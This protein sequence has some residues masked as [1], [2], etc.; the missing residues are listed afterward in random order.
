MI[1]PPQ[2][3]IRIAALGTRKLKA[4][5][6]VTVFVVRYYLENKSGRDWKIEPALQHVMFNGESVTRAPLATTLSASQRVFEAKT[7]RT[8]VFDLLYAYPLE[9]EPTHF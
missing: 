4:L 7:G 6:D 9:K 8:Q 3:Q 5:N 2:G 1:F